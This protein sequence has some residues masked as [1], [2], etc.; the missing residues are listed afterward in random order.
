MT[1]DTVRRV[2]AVSECNG[3]ELRNSL[4]THHGFRSEEPSFYLPE[5]DLREP[6]ET[7]SARNAV[8]E[9][10]KRSGKQARSYTRRD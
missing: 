10:C 6:A 4:E 3:R 2:V 9:N 1:R 8:A 5:A 7:N